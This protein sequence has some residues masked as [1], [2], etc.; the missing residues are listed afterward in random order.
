[1]SVVDRPG[2]FGLVLHLYRG[3]KQ[4]PIQGFLHFCDLD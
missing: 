2:G 3:A 4:H 1:M